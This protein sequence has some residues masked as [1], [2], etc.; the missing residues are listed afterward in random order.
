MK[1]IIIFL[2]LFAILF[3]AKAQPDSPAGQGCSLHIS[4]LTC[5]PGT[6][7]YSTFGH[8]AIRVTDSIT[9]EDIVFNYGTFDFDDPDFYMKF[10][11][12]KLLYF[13]SV[14][15][16]SDFMMQYQYEKR[17]VTEQ[18]L[19][20]SCSEKQNLLNAL[21]ENAKEENKYYKYD[22]ILNNC[23]TRLRDIVFK[24]IQEPVVTTDIRP[25]QNTTFR[26]LIH[27]YLDKGK[28][29]WSE[30]GIDI[31]LGA[32]LDK[33]INDSEAMFLPDYLLKG[34]D[35]TLIGNNKLVNKKIS[36]LNPA[37]LPSKTSFLSPMIVFSLLFLLIAALSFMKTTDL[38]FK[39]FD[40]I[41]FFL[42]GALGILLLFMWFGT[43]HH[44]CKYNLNLF[45]ALPANVVIAFLLYKKRKW[46]VYYLISYS[47]ILI[48]LIAFGWIKQKLNPALNPIMLIMLIRS[49][50]HY[51]KLK[52]N[53]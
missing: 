34:F 40:F 47:F 41:L 2:F 18:D 38:F 39:F 16:F 19:N 6:E 31:L 17:G 8:S 23:T 32:P 29:Y 37:V 30:L 5:S 49:M 24:T 20:L 53:A 44:A 9:Q 46:V 52:S 15:S 25:E 7:L 14:T 10:T 45:W 13:V 26:D 33:K 21:I 36:L 43:D 51:K 4:L 22:F 35:S 48:T 27:E 28:E 12:G 3:S 1:K 50:V 11:R 42:T